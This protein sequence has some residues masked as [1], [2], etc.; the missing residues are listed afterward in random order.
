MLNFSKYHGLGNDFILFDA[1]KNR[2]KENEILSKPQFIKRIC[3]RRFGV[4][5]D[6]LIIASPSEQGGDVKMRIF[7]SDG[8][9]AEMCG[10]GI[11][12][13]C[14]FLTDNNH[15]DDGEE[16]RVETL[17]GLI[18]SKPVNKLDVL[19][20]M[21]RPTL[22]SSKVPTLL[23][24]GPLGLPQGQIE[25]DGEIFEVCSVGM[26]N[27]HLVIIVEDIKSIQL[28]KYGPILENHQLFPSK[29]NVHFVQLKSRVDLNL[30]V[31]ERGSGPTLA[32]G[33][34]A[35]AALVVCKMLGLC[36]SQ[37]EIKLPGGSLK[38]SWDGIDSS[39]FITGEAIGVFKASLIPNYIN[40]I[41]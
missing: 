15:F 27:P 13:L 35:C 21:G 24:V 23:P 16:I 5:A 34:G 12:C 19:V 14:R 31:W 26:G 28:E 25:I 41:S 18:I 6:G 7:N 39:V 20:N 4:G 36:E 40:S 29:T 38:V 30:L 10:N 3:D 22:I 9:E 11:R 1:L 33:T 37:V 32:C 8:S 2:N 17:A